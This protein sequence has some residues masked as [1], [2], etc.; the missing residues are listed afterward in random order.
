G[1][2]CADGGDH[3]YRRLAAADGQLVDCERSVSQLSP[4][5]RDGTKLATTQHHRDR[6]GGTADVRDGD[7]SAGIVDLAQPLRLR[8]L[9]SCL[10][11]A[12]RAGPLLEKGECKRGSSLDCDR[13]R[14]L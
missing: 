5:P 6:C 8:G 2:G 13:R 10:P 9:G 3:V 12:D 4:S 14:Y 7:P 1:P 11:V